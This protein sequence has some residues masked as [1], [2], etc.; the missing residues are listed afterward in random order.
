MTLLKPSKKLNIVFW[1]LQISLLFFW[2]SLNI[3]GI[4]KGIWQLNEHQIVYSKMMET[5]Y[6]YFTIFVI[7]GVVFYDV[8]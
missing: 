1:I 6:P 5:L 7:S 4:K 8:Y 3:A 2:L